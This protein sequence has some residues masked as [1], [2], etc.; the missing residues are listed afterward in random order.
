MVYNYFSK[1]VILKNER[2]YQ[3][4]WE[5]TIGANMGLARPHLGPNTRIEVYR[6][7]QYTLRDVLEQHFDTEM[8]DNLFRE[9]GVIAGK[10]FYDR[11]LSEANDISTLVFKIQ[12]SLHSLGIGIFRMENAAEDS[13]RFIFTVEEDLDCSGLPD[14]SAVVCVYDEGF[15]QG[16]LGSFTGKEFNVREIDCWCTGARACRFEAKMAS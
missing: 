9:A 1:G 11:Y 5:S 4:D 16:I 8:S 6:L 15:I 10:A 3:F 7:F 12:D 2:K 14:T 13:S